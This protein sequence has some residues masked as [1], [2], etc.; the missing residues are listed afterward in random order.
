MS[1]AK[2][3][4]YKKMTILGQEILPG[5]GAQ[6][7]RSAGGSAVLLAREGVYA[8]VRLRS[9]EVRRREAAQR[10]GAPT[11]TVTD[12]VLGTGAR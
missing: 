6:V 8:Q 2:Q 11:P 1:I 7:A 10:L 12:R 3:K 5:K 9:G 4:S